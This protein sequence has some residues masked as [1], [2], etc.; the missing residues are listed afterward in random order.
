MYKERRINCLVFVPSMLGTVFWKKAVTRSV[1]VQIAVLLR[2]VPLLPYNVLNYLLSVTPLS[3]TSYILASWLGMMVRS[4]A[5]KYILVAF[6]VHASLVRCHFLCDNFLSGFF[7]S[8][9][10][11]ESSWMKSMIMVD[12]AISDNSLIV[13]AHHIG[14]CL[15]GY[16]NQGHCRHKSWGIAFHEISHSKYFHQVY[17]AIITVHQ[18]WSCLSNYFLFKIG[19]WHCMGTVHSDVKCNSTTMTTFPSLSWL[20]FTDHV[21]GWS[22]NNRWVS[23]LQRAFASWVTANRYLNTLRS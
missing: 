11:R 15:R 6:C 3:T 9:E 4:F 13:A 18:L 20:H 22:R 12:H 1:L 2:F 14:I 23:S 19:K 7:Q 16:Y 8:T 5:L 17:D 21:G 10:G